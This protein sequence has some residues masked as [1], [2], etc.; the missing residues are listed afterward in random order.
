MLVFTANSR[1]KL[2]NVRPVDIATDLIQKA[3]SNLM[4]PFIEASAQA[5]AKA[6]NAAQNA[7]IARAKQQSEV[8]YRGRR[9]A[10]G[11]CADLYPLRLPPRAV[12]VDM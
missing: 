8:K 5:Q 1:L 3:L 6:T 4:I 11:R 10:G 2:L 12:P 7:G 9:V